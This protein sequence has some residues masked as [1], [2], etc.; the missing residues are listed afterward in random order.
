MGLSAPAEYGGQGLPYDPQ[1]DRCRN[2]SSA[3]TWPSACIPGLTQGAIAA[4][5]VHGSPSREADLPAEDGRRQLDRH[6]EPYRAALRHGS[7]VSS[8]PRRC[9]TATGPMPSPA[10]RSSSRRASTTSPRTSFTSFSPASRARRQGTKGISLFVVPKF[11]VGADGTLGERNGVS[12]GSIEHKM[13]IHGNSTCVMN[14][15]GAKG[16]LIGEA[17]PRPRRHV[18]DDE[19]GA[20]RGRRAGPRAIGGRLPE[21]RRPTPRSACRAVR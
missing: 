13:G 16:W 4:L 6:H 12:C 11:F 19:R 21:R 2:S 14:Y 5:F 17:E 7:R 15:D 20:P 9:R 1:H 8:R 18:R 3:R 10:P